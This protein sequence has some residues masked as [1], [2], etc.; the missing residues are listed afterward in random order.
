MQPLLFSYLPWASTWSRE[1]DSPP[2][3]RYFIMRKSGMG[4]SKPGLWAWYNKTEPQRTLKTW[5]GGFQIG[6]CTLAWTFELHCWLLL[7]ASYI[8][9]LLLYHC[10]WELQR[11]AWGGP[12]WTCLSP[13]SWACCCGRTSLVGDDK[14]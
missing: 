11:A 8:L 13:L 6:C 4:A 14:R 5:A 7:Y 12:E 9:V 1:N 3:E 10:S 2:T